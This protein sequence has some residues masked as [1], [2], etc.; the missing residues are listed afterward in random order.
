[1]TKQ[2]LIEKRKSLIQEKKD[3][4]QKIAD[5]K[6]EARKVYNLIFKEKFATGGKWIEKTKKEGQQNKILKTFLGGTRHMFGYLHTNESMHAAMDRRGVNSIIQGPASNIGFVGGFLMKKLIWDLFESRNVMLGIKLCNA[7][8]DALISEA[9]YV[10]IPLANYMFLHAQ[11]TL[12]HCYLRDIL[13][14]EVNTSFETDCVV[15]PALSEMY[16]ATRWNDQVDSIK[17]SLEWKRDN[18]GLKQPIDKIMKVVEHNAKIIFEMRRREIK[19]QLK[20]EIRVSYDMELNYD[21]ALN[22]GL[23]FD[24]P[25][26]E[27]AVKRSWK[28]E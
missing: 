27:K 10:N 4:L 25:E 14:F 21:N 13:D 15:G 5:P 23:I 8:H 11:T 24:N 9:R 7:V 26:E 16:E 28:D 6:A 20:N 19:H 22:I 3:I 2:E 1:M 18:L 17:K 12:T